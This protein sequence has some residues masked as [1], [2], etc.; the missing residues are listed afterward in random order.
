MGQPVGTRGENSVELL[1]RIGESVLGYSCFVAVAMGAM[2]VALRR[3]KQTPRSEAIAVQVALCSV[4]LVTAALLSVA[5]F[6]VVVLD[7]QLSFLDP[8]E[9]QAALEP[10]RP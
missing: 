1:L 9:P 2:A 5:Y 4:Y 8:S 3:G 6:G 10:I 7:A